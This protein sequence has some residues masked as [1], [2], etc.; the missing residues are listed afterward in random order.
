MN[1]GIE[2]EDIALQLAMMM[3]R[4]EDERRR[5]LLVDEGEEEE[6]VEEVD[7]TVWVPGRKI[8]FGGT[9]GSGSPSVRVDG[10]RLEDVAVFRRGKVPEGSESSRF[11][12]DLEFAIRLSLAEQESRESSVVR[13]E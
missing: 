10:G 4:E 9:S 6:E 3:S 5:E 2:E 12:E 8:S 11:E 7:E 1:G 13:E